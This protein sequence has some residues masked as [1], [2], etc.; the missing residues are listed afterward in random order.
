MRHMYPS[1]CDLDLLLGF[2]VQVRLD[3]SIEE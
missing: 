3:N 2:I 1:L